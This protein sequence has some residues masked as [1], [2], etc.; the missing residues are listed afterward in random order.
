MN[1]QIQS[2]Q[3]LLSQVNTI[4]KSYEKVEQATGENFNLF[5]ILGIE[6]SEVKT[7]SAFIAHLLN[8][9]GEHGFSNLFLDE[10]IKLINDKPFQ[11]NFENQVLNFNSENSKAYKEHY[12][13]TVN[14]SEDVLKSTGGSIDILIKEKATN[15]VIL[16]ENKIDAGDQKHQLVRYHN[17]FRKGLLIYLTLS[18]NESSETSA[19]SISYKCLSY[20]EDIINWLE[21]CQKIAV[22]NPVVRETIKQY[23]NLIKKITYQNINS[24]MEKEIIELI[25]ENQNYFASYIELQKINLQE[26]VINKSVD[27][28]IKRIAKEHNLT[29]SNYLK[30][31]WA[32]FSFKING[33]E[34]YKNIEICFSTS[35]K[36]SI[37]DMVYG[38]YPSN[39][40]NRNLDLEKKIKEAFSENFNSY[41]TN[42]YNN[43]IVCDYFDEYRNWNDLET[44]KN[45]LFSTNEF[46]EAIDNKV[47]TIIDMLKNL[48]I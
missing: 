29:L 18:G 12:C 19:E 7:H 10:F 4:R 16:I 23:K 31:S 17:A 14:I 40:D 43:W 21:E 44:M 34:K 35:N 48:N 1:N 11:N 32:S 8:A 46:Y 9:E 26:H 6:R 45:I 5:S 36:N 41:I 38:L 15:N 24:Q 2:A 13:R 39:E 25:T 47:S 42:G 37:S 33:F 3:N 28:T 30:N 27:E 20:E 22:D